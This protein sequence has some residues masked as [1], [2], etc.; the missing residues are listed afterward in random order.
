M[1]I[2]HANRTSRV[3]DAAPPRLR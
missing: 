3:A 2:S 1:T